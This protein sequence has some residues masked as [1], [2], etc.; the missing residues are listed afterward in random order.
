VVAGLGG[1][2]T[3]VLRDIAYRVAPVDAGEAE[4]MLRELRAFSLLEGVRGQAPRDIRASAEAIERLSWLAYDF[5]DEISEIDV[6]PLVAYERGVLALDAL[7]IRT[8]EGKPK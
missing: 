8:R 6:N 3:E 5:R 2:H 4:A 1:I 7:V